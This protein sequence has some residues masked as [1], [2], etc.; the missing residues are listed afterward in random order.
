[1][2][3]TTF[4]DTVVLS[5]GATITGGLGIDVITA[6]A[7]ADTFRFASVSDST[8]AGMQDQLIGFD[9]AEDMFSFQGINFASQIQYIGSGG[10]S[11]GASQ[12]RLDGTLLQIDV[13]GDGQMGAGD[14]EIG[15]TDLQGTL[16]SANF[17]ILL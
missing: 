5:S 6:S 12:V 11:G 14:M 10:F 2:N 16:S 4:G 13:D 1:V 7:D 9:A 8:V 17:G 3:G 15:L